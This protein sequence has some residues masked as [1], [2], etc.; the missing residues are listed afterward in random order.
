MVALIGRNE[1]GLKMTREA[2]DAVLDGFHAFFDYGSSDYMTIGRLTYPV[3]KIVSKALPIVDIVISDANKPF[4]VQHNHAIDDLVAGLLV[5]DDPL[6]RRTQD[7]AD[8]LQETCALALQ[9]LALSDIGK[10]PLRS[11]DQV[12]TALRK[13]AAVDGTGAL[14]T[15]AQQH[16]V[17]AL[18]E[19][20]E[21][22]RQKAKAQA[23]AAADELSTS[24]DDVVEHVMLSYNWDHQPTIKR[25]NTALQGRGYA[26]WIDVEKMQGST[27][28]A[29]SAA[30]EDCAVMCYGIS[31]AYKESTNCRMEA[32][33]AFQQ[34]KDMV[35]LMMVEGYSANGWLGMMLGVRLWYGF[36]GSVL[37]S[38]GAF[39]GKMEELCRELGDRGRVSGT[40][41]SVDTGRSA[42]EEVAASHV[43]RSEVLLAALQSGDA[44]EAVTAILEHAMNVLDILLSSTPRKERKTAKALCE[45]TEAALEAIDDTVMMQLSMCEESELSALVECLC[46]V[47]SLA[48]GQAEGQSC[49]ETVSEALEVLQRCTD[50]VGGA[51]RMVTSAEAETRSRGLTVL[52]GLERVV[53]VEAAK[54]EVSAA[55]VL[56]GLVLDN[57]LKWSSEEQCAMWMSLFA[58]ALRNCNEMAMVHVI[59]RICTQA[60]PAM[61]AAVYSGTLRGREGVAVWN[62]CSA[63]DML[64]VEMSQQ[65]KDLAARDVMTKAL[66]VGVKE[67]MQ[68]SCTAARYGELLPLLIDQTADDDIALASGAGLGIMVP[69]MT[70]SVE[71]AS[72]AIASQRLPDAALAMMRR[73]SGGQL[74]RPSA[75]WKERSG[76]IH[77]DMLCLNMGIGQTLFKTV[78]FLKILPHNNTTWEDL[79]LE[80][81]HNLKINQEAELSTQKTMPWVSVG[82]AAKIVDVAAREQS[83]HESLLASGVVD[84]L[85]WTTA[86]DC[87][88][89]GASLASYTAGPMVALIGRNEGG[90]TLTREAIDAVLDGLHSYF[91]YGSSDFLTMGRLKHPVVHI[92]A[93]ALPIVDITIS[94]ANKPFVVQ[95]SNAIHDLV[96]GLLVDED[97]LDRRAQ[98]GADK[99]QATCA[100]ALQNL[101]LSD[102]GKATLRAHEKVVVALHK[103]DSEAGGAS[104]SDEARK[105]TSGALFELDEAVR[106]TVKSKAST[107]TGRHDGDVIEHV[108]LSYNWDHQPTIKRINTALK[109]RDYAVW[110]DIEKMQ[111]STVEAMSAAVEDC[112]VMCYGISKAYKESTNCRME[113]QYA[114]Q[115]Q[116]DMVPLMLE[117]G[118]SANGWLG[119]MLGVRLWYG[120]FGATLASEGAFEGKMDELCRE[121]GDRGHVP[122]AT[123]VAVTVSDAG[124]K[125]KGPQWVCEDGQRS[126][127]LT[128]CLEGAG[129]I[130]QAVG[131]KQRKELMLRTDVLLEGIEDNA[132][133]VSENWS[134]ELASAV[135]AATQQIEL[136]EG[137][138][139]NAVEVATA[140]TELLVALEGVV[141]SHVDRSEVLLAAL[142]SGNEP[143]T[144]AAVLE[145]A[146]DV[147]E[148]V[149]MLTPRKE[150][151]TAKALCERTE[152]ALELIDDTMMKQLS[153]CE[154]SELLVLVKCLCE[155]ETVVVGETERQ[156]CLETV[157]EALEALQRCSDPV[158]GAAQMIEAADFETRLRGLSVLRGLERVVLVKHMEAEVAVAQILIELALNDQ[159]QRTSEEQC[160][161]WMSLF[162][163]GLRNCGAEGMVDII[164][165]ARVEALPRI[166]ASAYSGKLWGREELA[167][168]FCSESVDA[169]CM[170]IA[171]QGGDAAIRAL[172]L[173]AIQA[174]GKAWLKLNCT[175]ARCAEIL[176]IAIDVVSDD[177]IVLASG[178]ALAMC[179]IL[180]TSGTACGGVV[181]ASLDLPTVL[182]ALLRR[183]SG[184]RLRQPATW[185]KERAGTVQHLDMIC[186]NGAVAGLLAYVVPLL[187]TLPDSNAA[188]EELLLEGIHILKINQEAELSAQEAMPWW[189]VCWAARLVD[190]ATHEQ[191]RHE[192]LLASGVVD[193]LMWTTAHDC[194]FVVA[195]IASYTAGPMV[196]LIGRNEG[197]LTLTREAIDAVLNGFHTHFDYDNSDYMATWRLKASVKRFISKAHHIGDI[198]ISD[199]NKSFVVQHSHAIDDLVA[200]L[201]VHD[202]LDR[203]SQDG[204][205][206]L[207][208]TCAFALQ[209]LAL[210]DIGKGPLRSHDGVMAALRK[211]AKKGED[212]N[213]EAR[214]YAF[215]ALFELDETVR[216]Q[217][218]AKAAA[219][220]AAQ[221]NGESAVVEH[222]MLS[223]NWD[224][225]PTIKRINTAL[226]ARDY[227]VWIDVE[228]MQGSTVEAMSAAV[229]DCA[230]MC[231]GISKAYKE[232]TNCRMEAQ[233]AFQQQKDMVPLMM[234]EGY[235]ANGW[236][237]MM[238]G[239]R[240]WYGFFGA[241]L[242]S[243]GAFEGKMGELCRELG[244]R[245]LVSGTLNATGSIAITNSADDSSLV[246]AHFKHDGDRRLDL[247][248]ECLES[249]TRM[250]PNVGRKQRKE[251]TLRM[252]ALLE[253]IED[254]AVWVVDEWS[255]EQAA[256]VAK[257]A[258]RVRSMESRASSA[259]AAEVTVAV[260][261]LLVVLEEVAA[262]HVD[263]SEVLLAALHSGEEP[264][265]VVAVLEHAFKVLDTLSSSTPRKE[266]QIVKALCERTEAALDTIDDTIMKQLSVCDPSELSVLVDCLC[267]V[268][269]LVV[270][271]VERQGC[272]ETVSAALEELQRC[273]NPVA[274]AARKVT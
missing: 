249:A 82:W 92:I 172:M 107:Q 1:G 31:K 138:E 52:R 42:V 260:T 259:D 25:I 224:H 166:T 182:L 263:R 178:A 216:E 104:M 55:E 80:G 126:I 72:V 221:Q 217:A 69:L 24:H 10:G 47:E 38:E 94:D 120:F 130:L 218:R 36:F 127:M 198:V 97:P 229:E 8:K 234:V 156:S 148:S 228:K 250:V 95:H 139:L 39:E 129:R 225:Q 254:D 4:V 64:S 176:P 90:L 59:Y 223:Y 85:M 197:G 49:L 157:S 240:L 73:A 174:G 108:M 50:S 205:D 219:E 137:K 117:E 71:C 96:A 268:E 14:G 2:V 199:A 253:C 7:G 177:D 110:I 220:S 133:W 241:T 91:D 262:S 200:G 188:W 213:E 247:L 168:C 230:V 112:A 160:A 159:A 190:V 89:V 209:N 5:D 111:G 125:F 167:V 187:K 65:S 238:L 63:I 132:T 202:P 12:L 62:C 215:G 21:A 194:I 189:T 75:W 145:H 155:V 32:Q 169:L 102:I 210:S 149:L 153:M 251:L 87:V 30:V 244:D 248:T 201:L 235:S 46:S 207:Q 83:R 6:K 98:E 121:L 165:R 123:S 212:L 135:A 57:P 273:S 22:V 100:L 68:R 106:Q 51:A 261:E 208:A 192:S 115:Q 9:N 114:F 20:D 237:G 118:Y 226:Q 265:V 16:A 246:A 274:G 252:D 171:M 19:L 175:A 206:K 86:H 81:I 113:A 267:S 256:T 271:E 214:Q 191:F 164:Y 179:H 119:M 196:A 37:A 158:A 54:A 136:M 53:L 180:M 45:R 28:E 239:V 233:Y 147:L 61:V 56:V 99:L 150:R 3:V 11:H 144:I 109:R 264:E 15:E 243:E 60:W 203:R 222:V 236:L 204:A 163:L 258:D 142:Q 27:V 193:A 257:A 266:R 255:I 140:V 231:Y 70:S 33:Y 66:K 26:V 232:S 44:L 170:E 18:F 84:A 134:A 40:A 152:A 195:S 77:F 101:A 103:L 78:P 23:R 128:E 131:R 76:S 211:V 48:V 143:G 93:R 105:Y 184:G 58:L 146:F 173:K 74:R 141:A 17:E 13:V 162:A 186:L 185:W 67:V 161:V 272:I 79:L 122:S 269:L 116:K 35:P 88:W 154:A 43:D 29:M 183:L 34:Q 245:G 181:T 270:G 242:A 124:D 41:T 227:A 151:K